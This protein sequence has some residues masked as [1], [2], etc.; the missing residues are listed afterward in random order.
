[1]CLAKNRTPDRGSP[2]RQHRCHG[3]LA[4]R[5]LS[6]LFVEN[7][8]HA[9]VVSVM[10]GRA[11]LARGVALMGFFSLF[12][13]SRKPGPDEAVLV[14]LRQAKSDLSKPHEVEFFLYLPT[15]SAAE[16]VADQIRK[17]GFQAEVKASA[18]GGDWLCFA[19][20]IMVPT[21][22]E[23]QRIRRDF[24]NI[25]APLHGEYDGWGTSVDPVS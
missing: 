16:Q 12:G 4:R 14:Q 1:V 24:E 10:K 22:A 21:L 11:A 20:R 18:K 15:Q 9:D 5:R 19:T 7:G 2:R 8:Y 3:L 6:R 23:L 25:L 17:D 13:C